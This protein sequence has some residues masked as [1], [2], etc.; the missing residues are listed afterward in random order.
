MVKLNDY[1]IPLVIGA[2]VSIVLSK[3]NNASAIP[4][5]NP[6]Y[7]SI[8]K[9]QAAAV[10]KLD[11]NIQTLESVKQ[12]NLGIAQSILN[13]EKS[14]SD[15]AISKIQN[16]LGKTQS[17]ISQQQQFK[18]VNSGG[19][20][21]TRQAVYADKFGTQ[22]YN[23]LLKLRVTDLDLDLIKQQSQYD[24]AQENIT[25]ANQL[26]IRQHGEI[27]RLNEEYQTRFGS[28]SRYG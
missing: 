23:D 11:T 10:Q 8:D 13:Y 27:D 20:V 28:L 6:Y 25:K 3:K 5:I 7:T 2:I 14:L 12:S 15:L 17:F 18:P 1:I 26:V 22:Q 24:A 9:A 19:S 4:F 21:P 16:E